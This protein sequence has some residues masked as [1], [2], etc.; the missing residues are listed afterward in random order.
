[1]PI[2]FILAGVAVVTGAVGLTKGVQ[3]I[4]NNSEANDIIAQAEYIFED[5]K[6]RLEESRQTTTE[7]L[8]RLGEL[9]LDVW[10]HD[11]GLFIELFKD[12]KNVKLENNVEL[13][14]NLEAKI[15]DGT[16]TMLNM[17][18]ASL[19]A[20]EVMNAGVGSLGAGALA[21]IASYGGA[22]MFAS[23]STGTA[24]SALSGVAAT[25]ATM[26][27]FGGGSLAAG[28]LGMAGGAAVLGGIVM[29]PVLAV[30]G[31]LM[32]A[33]SD[34]NFSNARKT[35]RQAEHA[36]EEMETAMTILSGISGL[37]E[38]YSHFIYSFRAQYQAVLSKLEAVRNRNREIQSRSISNR[39]K[40][41]FGGKFKIDFEK[42]DVSEQK[43]LQVAL[44]MSQLLNMVLATALLTQNSNLN[45]EAVN[46]LETVKNSVPRLTM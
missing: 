26:A 40:G 45:E 19:K 33:K 28:G 46:I 12:F 16:Q 43:F 10:S 34:E 32:K 20:S 39:V 14:S 11:I 13:D 15:H 3:A 18:T 5:A 6:E 9:K 1:M 35:Y 27:W 36:V 29:G 37:A 41:V 21:G 8:N 38:N 44:V 17:E 31:F 42:L 30:A 23:A 2:P 22:M 24:I 4:S 7:E 25:N